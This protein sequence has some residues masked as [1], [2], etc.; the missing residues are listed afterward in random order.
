MR[1]AFALAL[2]VTVGLG[3][4][5]AKHRGAPPRAPS[6]GERLAPP[7]DLAGWINTKPLSPADMK[8]KVRLV[9]FWTF[10]NANCQRTILAM[11]EIHG[12]YAKKGL[13]VLGIHS[14]E[15]PR[16][17]DST[18]LA[19]AVRRNGIGF[20]V[21]LDPDRRVFDAFEN[22]AWPALYL[23]NRKGRI[24]ATHV[25]E[26]SVG[27]R[28]WRNLCAAIDSAFVAREVRPS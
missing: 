1:R 16:E 19:A 24:V 7:I 5:G 13:L 26:L 12:L 3:A 18:A 25:G 14:P 20:A 6:T 22:R 17:R 21:A 23:V 11:R 27:T 28:A 10:G 15:F 4:L 9:E 8:G 2:L